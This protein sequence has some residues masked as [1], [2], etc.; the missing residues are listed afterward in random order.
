MLILG[1]RLMGD[2]LP[3]RAISPERQRVRDKI[4]MYHNFFRTKVQ[5]K[6]GNMLKM[7]GVTQFVI[8]Y[9]FNK[10]VSRNGMKRQQ[11]LLKNG[12]KNASF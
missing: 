7:V 11:N 3:Y 2:I 1:P 5:P 12:R 6:A 8:G 9:S 10:F 4:V